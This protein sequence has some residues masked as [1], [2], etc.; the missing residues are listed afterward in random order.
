MIQFQPCNINGIMD[1]IAFFMTS[2]KSLFLFIQ[3]K[4]TQF[5]R[6]G[7]SVGP[8]HI[9]IEPRQLNDKVC[10]LPLAKVCLLPLEGDVVH[11]CLAGGA[12]PEYS[13]RNDEV[14]D[15]GVEETAGQLA[16][17]RRRTAIISLLITQS[18]LP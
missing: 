6:G 12:G 8:I 15:E 18:N 16:W 7:G 5:I 14:R 9:Y 2:L 13:A 11:D 1:V 17:E 3:H 4:S 10:L